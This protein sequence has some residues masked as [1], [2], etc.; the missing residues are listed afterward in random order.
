MM[1][2][3]KSQNA[4]HACMLRHL[5]LRPAKHEKGA[6]YAVNPRISNV[7][8]VAKVVKQRS[9]PEHQQEREKSKCRNCE[10]GGN[11]DRFGSIFNY[12]G[13]CLHLY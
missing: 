4:V 8:W 2:R 12:C 1:L 6:I 11:Y 9:N 3:S 7:C 5:T 13:L 10:N